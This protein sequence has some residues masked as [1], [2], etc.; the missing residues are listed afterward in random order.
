MEENVSE[1]FFSEHSVYTCTY[2]QWHCWM[3]LVEPI[4]FVSHLCSNVNKVLI[5][6]R[7]NA[8][9]SLWLEFMFKNCSYDSQQQY[10]WS[11]RWE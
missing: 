7:Y 6:H 4:Q 5:K 11:S 10:N 3:Q 9:P 8:K 2:I 1:C